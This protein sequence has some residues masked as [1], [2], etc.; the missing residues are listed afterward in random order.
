MNGISDRIYFRLLQQSNCILH[1][2]CKVVR[3]TIESE[4]TF[5]REFVYING[6]RTYLSLTCLY[7]FR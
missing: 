2:F 4:I 1:F 6:P 7:Y 5:H 3:S